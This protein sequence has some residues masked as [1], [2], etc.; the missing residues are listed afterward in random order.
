MCIRDRSYS[1]HPIAQSLRAACPQE[2]DAGR[3]Q[4]AEEVAGHGIRALVDGRRVYAGNGK[5]MDEAGVTW[6]ECHRTGTV[7]HVAVDGE[8]AG[9]IVISDEVKPDA[10]E[11]IRLLKKEGVRRTVML[12]GD[13]REV[14]E[15]VARQLGCL[16]YTSSK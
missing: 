5:L 9:H 12:T 13:R 2:L 7:I 4:Q 10:A 8:Y 6:R 15:A 3:V 1:D 14:G 16:L 11:A